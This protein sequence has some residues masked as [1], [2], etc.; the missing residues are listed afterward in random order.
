MQLRQRFLTALVPLIFSPLLFAQHDV[1]AVLVPPAAR[2]AAPAFRLM[3]DAGKYV[4][5]KDFKGKVVLLD[6]WATE[7]G[8]CVLEIPYFIELEQ[9][10]KDKEFTAVGVS[11]DIVYED[12]KSPEEAWSKV[13]PFV[14]AHKLNY[15]IL[16][17]DESVSREYNLQ[18]YP[19][20]CLLDKNGKIAATYVGVV[21]KADVETNIKALLAE[22]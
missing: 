15:P 13:K 3:N 18:A 2:K 7:C 6:F 14:A 5:I 9:A 19:M 11:M 17:G 16:M 4:E 10:Y 12:L 8:G 1:H 20:T 21:S 22:K